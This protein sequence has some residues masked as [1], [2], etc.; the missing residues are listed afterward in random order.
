M[1][2]K[3]SLLTTK[4][5]D[6]SLLIDYSTYFKEVIQY[7][8]YQFSLVSSTLKHPPRVDGASAFGF[9]KHPHKPYIF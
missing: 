8:Y 4:C 7:Y 3:D 2:L 1:G 5:I 9:H 6:L